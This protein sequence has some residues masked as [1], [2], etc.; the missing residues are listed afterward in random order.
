[1][2][3]LI[4]L[5]FTL[6]IFGC[7]STPQKPSDTEA[8]IIAKNVVKAQFIDPSDAEIIDER[9]RMEVN[10]DTS[11]VFDG[12]VKAPNKLGL[13]VPYEFNVGIK[14]HGG[15]WEQDSSWTVRFCHI[16]NPE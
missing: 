3:K 5:L 7:D 16:T 11:W 1:M 13:K 6:F 14:W 15:E 8:E 4:P 2:K 12:Y 10:K 9:T